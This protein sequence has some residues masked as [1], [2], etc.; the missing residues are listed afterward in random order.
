M[1]QVPLDA[2]AERSVYFVLHQITADLGE[3]LVLL[4]VQDADLRQCTGNAA[5]QVGEHDEGK[6]HNED[7][8][9]ALHQVLRLNMHRSWCEL[10]NGPV[11]GGDVLVYHVVALK[12]VE[13]DPVLFPELTLHSGDVKPQT[14]DHVVDDQQTYNHLE[15]V[16]NNV[17][18]LTVDYVINLLH[19]RLELDDAYKP[20]DAQATQSVEE[21]CRVGLLISAEEGAHRDDPVGD[22]DHQV[23]DKPSLEVVLRNFP[24]VHDGDSVL[25][26]SHGE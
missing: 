3:L 12:L 21:V 26:K 8:V 19:D 15:D 24:R 9:D 16:C 14:G 6:D 4:L 2:D 5:D 1:L 23:N 18:V 20:D 17:D 22:H 11:E 7:R 10:C 25:D 13:S